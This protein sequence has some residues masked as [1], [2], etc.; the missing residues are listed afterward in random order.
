LPLSS[1]RAKS[2][3]LSGLWSPRTRPKQEGKLHLE[4]RRNPGEENA[5]VAAHIESLMLNVF[6]KFQG[7]KRQ[8]NVETVSF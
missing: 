5:R 1:M 4:F 7:G 2:A 6:E 3:S 8:K